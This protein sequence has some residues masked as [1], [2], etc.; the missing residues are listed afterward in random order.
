M[1]PEIAILGSILL[2]KGQA[3]DEINL[4]PED[5]NDLKLGRV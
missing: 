3:L 4:V 1:N 5:F 2:S